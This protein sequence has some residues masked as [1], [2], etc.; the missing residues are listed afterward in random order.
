MVQ[1]LYLNWHWLLLTLLVPA[2]HRTEVNANFIQFLVLALLC[3]DEQV[4]WVLCCSR[5]L[6]VDKVMELFNYVTMSCSLLVSVC[7]GYF[8]KIHI[9]GRIPYNLFIVSPFCSFIPRCRC[10]YV[11]SPFVS[12]R[13]LQAHDF[14]SYSRSCVTICLGPECLNRNTVF[15]GNIW[16]SAGLLGSYHLVSG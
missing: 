3:Q 6:L 14:S 9:A 5:F 10:H 8:P 16:H 7:V 13:L 15:V 1:H 2:K 11:F 12:D 4:S